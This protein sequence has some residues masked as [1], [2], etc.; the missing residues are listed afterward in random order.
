MH[1]Y[2]RRQDLMRFI[3]AKDLVI[4]KG[5]PARV[6]IYEENEFM[7]FDAQLSQ[8]PRSL[9][10]IVR[11][12]KGSAYDVQCKREHSRIPI[13]NYVYFDHFTQSGDKCK[14]YLWRI[15]TRNRV[16]ISDTKENMQESV[17]HFI[18]RGENIDTFEYH[19]CNLYRQK[20]NLQ[21]C[22]DLYWDYVTKITWHKRS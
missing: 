9:A 16:F 1:M 12:F 19:I 14:I 8:L 2:L 6:R 5:S 13:S 10:L 21:P 20:Y 18:E 11:Y 7:I 22:R 3:E 15:G 17:N 4:T